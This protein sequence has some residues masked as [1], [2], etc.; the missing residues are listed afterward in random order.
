MPNATFP[1]PAPDKGALSIIEAARFLG[2]SRTSIF[3]AIKEGTLRAVRLRRRTLIPLES[4]RA[5]LEGG[6]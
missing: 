4:L 1:Q 5:F 6:R 2:V 3:M